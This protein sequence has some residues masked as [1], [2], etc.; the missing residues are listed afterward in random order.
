[1][2]DALYR[3]RLRW[4]QGAGAVIRAGRCEPLTVKPDLG[5]A[6]HSLDFS[7]HVCE[8]LNVDPWSAPRE[9]TPAERAACLAY[10]EKAAT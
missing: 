1:M 9:L 5:F 6:F 4:R 8:Q 10:V 7:P 2:T 3:T